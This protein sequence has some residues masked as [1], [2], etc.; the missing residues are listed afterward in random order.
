[1]VGADAGGFP[2]G[3]VARRVGLVQLE[4]VERVPA[5]VEEGDTERPK[6]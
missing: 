2:A 6:T 3:I 4:A 1:V 5:D